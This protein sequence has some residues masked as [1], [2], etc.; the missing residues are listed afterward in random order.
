MK[1]DR[2]RPSP[3]ATARASA[4]AAAWLLACAGWAQA[5]TGAAACGNPFVN[6]FGPWDIRSAAPSDR[7]MVEDFHFTPGIE[8]MTRPRNTTMVDMAQDVA[9]TLNVFPNHHRALITMERLSERWKRD[10]APGTDRPVECWFD[11]AVRFRPDDTV[12]RALYAQFLHK[13]K[14]TPDAVQQLV[15]ATEHAKDNPLS[16]YNIGLVFLEIG[17]FDRAL[18]Q[19]HKALALGFPRQEL[20]DKLKAAGR[21][22]EPTA[23]TASAAPVAGAASAPP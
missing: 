21:W 8:S 12:V 1:P 11:R 2:T 19:A 13:R 4:S 17:E 6:H 14:R 23:S 10:P 5:Q 22:K 16:H 3:A 9:Y 18:A 20:A 15:A 7:K